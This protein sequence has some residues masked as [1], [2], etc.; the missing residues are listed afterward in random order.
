MNSIPAPSPYADDQILVQLRM[1]LCIQ[2]RFC[3]QAVDLQLLSAQV[4]KGTD[5]PGYL[6]LAVLADLRTHLE[7][8]KQFLVVVKV[9]F[10]GSQ[11]FQ[12]LQAAFLEDQGSD[13]RQCIS[14]IGGTG[15]RMPNIID[16]SFGQKHSNLSLI[17]QNSGS[18]E[19]CGLVPAA[20][21][22]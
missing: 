8:S 1:L 10:Q 9:G 19:D 7:G 2:K 11:Q 14:S 22:Q 5:Q 6:L 17:E 16:Q 15:L 21:V 3:I 4:G 18:K 13:S 12:R 20:A